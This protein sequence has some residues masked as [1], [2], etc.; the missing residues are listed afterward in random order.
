MVAIIVFFE[1]LKWIFPTFGL[2][3]FG[4]FRLFFFFISMGRNFFLAYLR[5]SN[6]AS[7]PSGRGGD[8]R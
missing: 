2:A 3:A 6:K 8:T 5:F 4:F 1:L 7:R